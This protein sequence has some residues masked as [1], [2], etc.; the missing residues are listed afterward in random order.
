MVFLFLTYFGNEVSPL[1]ENESRH[2][3]TQSQIRALFASTWVNNLV[4]L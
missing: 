2:I 4:K 3:T 1:C